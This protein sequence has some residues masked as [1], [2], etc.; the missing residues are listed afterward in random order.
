[1]SMTVWN[2]FRD[3]ERML[4]R[5]SGQRSGA[6]GGDREMTVADWYPAVDIHETPDHYE[7]RVELPGVAKEDVNITIDRGLLTIRGEKKL[8]K[9]AEGEGKTHR[10]ESTY[11]TFVRSFTLPDEVDDA[12]VD[13]RYQD[14]I[15]DLIIPKTEK[16]KPKA[17][18]V[19][20][21]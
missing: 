5:W 10:V 19:K 17:I 8:V 16:A 11:G 9:R 7:L 20:V 3:M 4:D 1:M 12:K 14:G 15:L 6:G 21:K 18:E 13:A 2:P